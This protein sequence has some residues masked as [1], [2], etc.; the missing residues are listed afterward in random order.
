MPNIRKATFD[1][2]EAMVELS[3]QKRTE[4]KEAQSQFWKKAEN[5]NVIQTQWFK[6]LLEHQ[7]YY[8]FVAE[9]NK[10]II[11]FVIGRIVPAPEVYNPGGLTM[12]ID[13][14][15]VDNQKSWI[16]VGKALVDV[17]R[18]VSNE[19]AQLLIVCGAHDQAKRE[20]LKAIDLSV[21]S[22]GYVGKV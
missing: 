3:D 15:C 12:M 19:V 5:A 11:G 14:F 2:V 7:D 9:E 6:E 13:D 21:A 22:E 4:Y 1:D 20:F 18:K 16:E 8:L 10:H 17:L